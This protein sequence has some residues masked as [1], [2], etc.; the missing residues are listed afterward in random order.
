MN[1]MSRTLL[2]DV[3]CAAAAAGITLALSAAFVAST[4]V[5]PGSLRAVAAATGPTASAATPHRW[6]GQPEPAVLVD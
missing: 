5:S 3:T 6:F 4:A 1:A 2:R